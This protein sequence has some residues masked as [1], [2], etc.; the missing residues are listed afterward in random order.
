M[1]NINSSTVFGSTL[2]GGEEEAG[3]VHRFAAEGFQG[4]SL[5]DFSGSQKKLLSFLVE[6][7]SQGPR[8]VQH[9]ATLTRQ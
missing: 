1:N 4:M 2:G 5:F 8:H 6:K 7:K 3:D 9:T